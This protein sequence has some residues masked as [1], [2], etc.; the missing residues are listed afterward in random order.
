MSGRLS[1]T[2]VASSSLR[3]CTSSPEASVH[4]EAASAWHSAATT[5][6][7]DRSST[8]AYCASSSRAS[9]R[10]SAGGVPSRVRKPCSACDAALRFLP[11]SNDQHRAPAAAE[12][13]RRAQAGGTGAD[14]D[15]VSSDCGRIG[16]TASL[17]PRARSP[18]SA[19]SARSD[20]RSGSRRTRAAVSAGSRRGDA[21]E[22]IEGA[23]A[24]RRSA[25]AGT[26]M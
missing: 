19:G 3:E 17:Q 6:L 25:R 14:D 5:S 12:H 20:S 22:R 16:A 23:V 7:V 11:L 2:P 21:L 9:R 13:Q 15:D 8:V 10:N 18:R 1:T 24:R 26:A 4:A